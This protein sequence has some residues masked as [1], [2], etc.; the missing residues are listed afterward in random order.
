MGQAFVDFLEKDLIK[1]IGG[2]SVTA[3]VVG[4]IV[5]VLRT[6]T[7][8]LITTK[9]NKNLENHK[10]DLMQIN[11][12]YRKIMNTEIEESKSGLMK[13]NDKYRQELN[14]EIEKLKYQ[15]QRNY[16]DFELYT[17]KK[18]ERYPELFKS[19]EIA[20]G[21][22][23]A[24]HGIYR[25]FSFENANKEDLEEY[26]NALGVT[27]RESQE[28]L[29]L[30]NEEGESSD[31]LSKFK[32]VRNRIKI[33]TAH[34]KWSV[35]NDTLIFNELYLSEDVSAQARVLLNLVFEYLENIYYGYLY[36]DQT[37]RDEMKREKVKL[38]EIMK[39]E[40]SHQAHMQNVDQD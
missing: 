9:F 36:Q 37:K 5:L 1:Y 6:I 7:N 39:L 30:W 4:A 31:A 12:K 32:A 29:D 11:D 20:Y 34:E 35:A 2:I 24:L 23:F 33:N 13:L 16:K 14:S 17:S 25:D 10:S 18:H 8:S 38:K 28:V 22:V 15:Q 27:R 21:S 40:L 3:L 19:I 26:L